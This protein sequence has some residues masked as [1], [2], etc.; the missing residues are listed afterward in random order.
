ML[1]DNRGKR[2]LENLAFE[3]TEDT[4]LELSKIGEFIIPTIEQVKSMSLNNNISMN[5]ILIGSVSEHSNK[6]TLKVRLL[7]GQNNVALLGEKIIFKLNE[8]DEEIRKLV[9]S[10]YNEI[11]PQGG[12]NEFASTTDI[13]F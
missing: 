6:I 1:Y 11:N 13:I 9:V 7:N 3:L 12:K 2:Q 5:Y 10:I 4:I 8:S